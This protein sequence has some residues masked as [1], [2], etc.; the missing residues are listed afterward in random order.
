MTGSAGSSFSSQAASSADLAAI[1]A[2][3]I[4]V[5]AM[6]AARASFMGDGVRHVAPVLAAG[7]PYLGEPRWLLFPALLYGILKPFQRP[8]WIGDVPQAIDFFLA[9]SVICGVVYVLLLRRWLI[10]R[11]VGPL[12]RAA[13]ITCAAMTPPLLLLSSDIAEPL[14]A[15]TI[16]LGG[17]VFAAT[18]PPDKSRIGIIV[19]TIAIALASLFY[20][21]TILAVALIPCAAPPGFL[22]DRKTPIVILAILLAVPVTMEISLVAASGDSAAGALQRIIGGEQNSLY[23]NEMRSHSLPVWP[24][25]AAVTMGPAENIIPIPDSHGIRG[26]AQR[27]EQRS[28][29]ADGIAEAAGIAFALA[30]FAAAIALAITHRRFEI[31]LALGVI[32]ILPVIRNFQYSYIKFY[33]LLPIIVAL[34]ASMVRGPWLAFAAA[35]ISIFNIAYAASDIASQRQWAHALESIY[36]T[37]TRNICWITRG[38]GPPQNWPGSCCSLVAVLSRGGAETTTALESLNDAALRK[39]L[40]QCFCASSEVVTGDITSES[41]GDLAN[42]ARQFRLQWEPLRNLVW[43]PSGGDVLLKHDAF[44]LVRYSARQKENLCTASTSSLIVRAP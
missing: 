34:C 12:T 16:A 40:K 36:T 32:L 21:G 3:T 6:A 13:A 27:L 41:E 33:V 9:A 10:Q 38:W 7:S 20:Q 43:Q 8:G 19:A 29:F 18:R 31:L 23:K 30:M 1:A 11:G 25:F 4:L 35:T 26:I 15:A 14:F 24:I 37:N 42:I 28:T 39:S 17:L 22:R 2:W 44:T 5:I